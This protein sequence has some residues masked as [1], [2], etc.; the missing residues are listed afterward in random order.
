MVL[1][2]LKQKLL[3]IYFAEAARLQQQNFLFVITVIWFRENWSCQVGEMVVYQIIRAK[4]MFNFSTWISLSNRHKHVIKGLFI[5]TRV[6][7]QLE[8]VCLVA[9][10]ILAQLQG[11]RALQ[12]ME[13]CSMLCTTYPQTGEMHIYSISLN[14]FNQKFNPVYLDY[15]NFSSVFLF[16]AMNL[17]SCM[18]SFHIYKHTQII[19]EMH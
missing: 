17:F 3:F 16:H 14:C 12:R 4:L 19:S 15:L 11:K 2:R 8:R 9:P 7:L 10:K 5:H 1:Q 6:L 18:V 13:R